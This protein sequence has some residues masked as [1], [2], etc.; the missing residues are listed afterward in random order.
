MSFDSDL[1]DLINNVESSL[2]DLENLLQKSS[3]KSQV[4]LVASDRKIQPENLYPKMKEAW[5]RASNL[6]K[7]ME[8]SYRDNQLRIN[9]LGEELKIHIES[10]ERDAVNHFNKGE[11]LE[12]QGILSFLSVIK[13]NDQKLGEYRE[14]CQRKIAEGN[15]VSATRRVEE[16]SM[17]HGPNP[18]ESLVTN[19]TSAESKQAEPSSAELLS[20]DSTPGNL[21]FDLEENGPTNSESLIAI[22]PQSGFPGIEME[23]RMNSEPRRSLNM[24]WTKGLIAL[25]AFALLLF[26]V[27]VRRRSMFSIHENSSGYSNPHSTNLAEN[28]IERASLSLNTLQAENHEFSTEKD[29]NGTVNQRPVSVQPTDQATLEKTETAQALFDVGRLQDA[30]TTCNA[31]LSVHPKNEFALMLRKR[32]QDYNSQQAKRSSPKD[33]S[34]K[35]RIDLHQPDQAGIQ[36]VQLSPQLREPAQS[37]GI[38]TSTNNVSHGDTE[39]PIEESAAKQQNLVISWVQKAQSAMISGRYVMPPQD[40]V[41]VYCRRALAIDPQ[42]T[43]AMLLKKE[44]FARAV[45]Q[46]NELTKSGKY[47]EARQFYS[48]LCYLSEHEDGF[49]FSVQELKQE[50]D[51][52]EFKAYPVVHQ[53]TIGSCTGRLRMNGYVVSFTPTVP[54]EEG[55]TERL[56]KVN[57]TDTDDKLKLK[58]GDKTYRF[59][60]NTVENIEEKQKNLR[61]I[62]G[63]L[64]LLLSKAN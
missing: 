36:R 22:S 3:E 6:L 40:N 1:K 14:L 24:N 27:Y 20:E 48:S 10:L 25:L 12:C 34:D 31:I 4:N 62:Y 28:G 51:K 16:N 41:L 63:Q 33:S 11:Y 47:D 53:H 52:L 54:S 17:D 37:V 56:T 61:N 43:Q 38:P 8:T 45:S 49:P 32:V 46:A 29:T 44:C 7:Q 13:P 21:A 26:A 19:G 64:I 30:V 59:R 23:F 15:D 2:Q 58:V 18:L 5:S 60:A 39:R 57:V 42:D 35:T 50:L 55:F 9:Q